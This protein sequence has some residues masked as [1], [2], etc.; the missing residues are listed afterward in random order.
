MQPPRLVREALDKW[1]ARDIEFAWKNACDA[2]DVTAKLTLQR[3]FPGKGKIGI[4]FTEFIRRNMDVITR[5]ATGGHLTVHGRVLT[6]CEHPDFKPGLHGLEEIIY[7]IR[8]ELTH[9][10]GISPTITFTDEWAFAS[11]GNPTQLANC[12]VIGL[13]FAV[14]VA[15]VNEY[16]HLPAQYTITLN[17][18]ACLSLTIS[19]ARK[20]MYAMV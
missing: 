7:K 17:G 9:K 11:G 18:K 10:N 8:C 19:G 16:G 6:K 13:I 5:C 15:P 2:V 20:Q 14:I 1:M 4:R 12:Y 3:A